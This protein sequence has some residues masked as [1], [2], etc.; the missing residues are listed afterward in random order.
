VLGVMPPHFQILGPDLQIWV[1]IGLTAAQLTERGNHY[2]SVVARLRPTATLVQA[3]VQLKTLATRLQQEQPG[4][5]RTTGMYAVPL[6]D[7]YVGDT[8]TALV[9][10]LAAAG[11]VLL[12]ACANVANLLLTRATGRAREMMIR[13]ALGADRK[14]LVRQLMTESLLLAGVGAALGLLVATASFGTLAH[15]IPLPLSG[16]SDVTMDL[17][18]L[19]ATAGAAVVT[20]ILFGLAP[21]WRASQVNLA[22]AASHRAPRSLAGG[23]AR[24]RS[25][26]VVG[27][28]A[29]ATVLLVGAGLLVTSFRTIRGVDLG[30]RPDGVLTLRLQ[31]PRRSYADFDKRAQLV[32]TILERVRAVPGVVT[33]G[34]TSAVPLVWKGGTAGFEPQER[35]LDPSLPYDANNRVVS[36]GYMETMGMTLRAG[37]F[38]GSEDDANGNPAAI[39]N[40]RMARQYWPGQDPIGRT[41]RVVGPS[42][43]WRTIVGVV[44]D[45]RVMGID[46]PTRAEM[47]FPIA[48]ARENWMWP[49]DVALRASRDP[50]L[51]VADVARAIWAVDRNQPISDVALMDDIIARELQDR[52]L[53][54]TLMA[55]FAGLALLLAAVGIYGVLAFSVAER[56]A[57]IGLRLALGGQPARIR[58]LFVRQGLVL[59]TVGLSLGLT[60]AVWS[61]ALLGKLLFGVHPRD[62]V[63]FVSQSVFLVA[64]CVVATYLPARRA[65]RVDPIEALRQY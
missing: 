63:T 18:V 5:N 65:S 30:F 48:Q 15:L 34:F 31:L 7:D 46:Q 3:N 49:R 33:A 52:R 37:R 11:C 62:P 4:T 26:L 64:V 44:A 23:H 17:S 47:Y 20:G 57:E 19:G 45:T 2:L 41:F 38:F 35:A 36:P 50:K 42:T 8:R 22:G 16:L 54:T 60:V 12:I 43:P 25:A 61:T 40:E 14:R 1:P 13:A 9:V 6:L 55:T 10:L 27:E 28:I 29:L 58:A 24:L 39:V 56:T 32:G 59:A 51:L 53:Q 21:A